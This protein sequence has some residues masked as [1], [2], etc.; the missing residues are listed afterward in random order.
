MGVCLSA[1]IKAESPCTTGTKILL[2]LSLSLSLSISANDLYDLVVQKISGF[3]FF[4][5]PEI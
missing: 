1:R 3:H 5:F 4:H 2:S